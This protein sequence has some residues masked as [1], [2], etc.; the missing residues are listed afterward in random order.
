MDADCLV[1]LGRVVDQDRI[2]G[3]CQGHCGV[4]DAGA[5]GNECRGPRGAWGRAKGYCD[6]ASRV[7]GARHFICRAV[8]RGGCVDG[9][10]C[11]VQGSLEGIC[12]GGASDNASAKVVVADKQL[13]LETGTEGLSVCDASSLLGLYP[14][15]IC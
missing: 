6:A 2:K 3:R 1:G 14:T 11:Q 12:R 7:P 5:G 9:G 4:G 13:T 8:G 15:Q 10:A